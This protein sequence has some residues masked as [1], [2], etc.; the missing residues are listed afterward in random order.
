MVMV[1]ELTVTRD[2]IAKVLKERDDLNNL[3][4]ARRERVAQLENEGKLD[5]AKAVRSLNGFTISEIDGIDFVMRTL[6]AYDFYY[7]GEEKG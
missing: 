7:N 4:V 1:K 5:Q 6:K 3:L 2:Q